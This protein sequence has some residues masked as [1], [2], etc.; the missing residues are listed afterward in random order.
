M[1]TCGIDIGARSI[2]IVLLND[3]K[4]LASSVNDTGVFP[5]ENADTA[6]KKLVKEAG[7][8]ISDV[9]RI[10]ATGYGRNFFKGADRVVSEIICHAEGVMYY[11]PEAKTVIDIGG[12]DSKVIQ[13]GDKGKVLSFAMN[14]R[15]A[16]GTGK[17]IEMIATTLNI[18]LEETGNTALKTQDFCEISSMCAVFAESE[19]VGLLHKGVPRETILR[20]IFRSIAKRVLGMTGT[21]GLR[22]VIAFTGGVARNLGVL[23]AIKQHCKNKKLLTPE[24][25]QITGALGAAII[26]AGELEQR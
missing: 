1:I 11:I 23:D 5:T 19:V 7:I 24:N 4:V 3:K 9:N 20:G 12:Q 14:D 17:F 25:P 18:P 21:L 13:I 10:I 2:D 16:A 26:A 22:E 6:Y 15:C 8:S